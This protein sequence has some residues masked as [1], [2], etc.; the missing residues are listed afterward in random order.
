[1]AVQHDAPPAIPPS[2]F[3]RS[4]IVSMIASI[5]LI[6]VPYV[7]TWGF[8]NPGVSGYRVRLAMGP[9]YGLSIICL[10]PFVQGFIYGWQCAGYR[11]ELWHALAGI[12]ILAVD[13]G[14]A[15]AIFGEGYIC[16][17]MAL[18]ILI[19]ILAVGIAVGKSLGTVR[20]RRLLQ[21]SLVPLVLSFVVVDTQNGPPVHS[22]AISDAVTIAAAPDYV[23]RYMVQY[24]VNESPPEYWLWKIGLPAPT[25]SVAA[26]AAI[27]AV[28]ECRFT[29]GVV[30]KEEITELVA[31]K[32]LIFKVTEQP[33]DPELLHHFSLDKGQLYLED[34]GDGTT[35]VIAT[36]WYRLFVEPALYFDWWAADNVR[37]VH[38]RVLNHVKRLAEADWRRDH[39]SAN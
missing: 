16:V 27:G 1:M 23:W 14:L 24:P 38:F 8:M 17:I 13:I 22:N 5:V 3:W 30:F 18:P 4:L 36:S 12:L 26:T 7:L 20:R 9:G 34:N 6:A 37:Q 31:N 29:H 25:Q 19:P 15:A 2:L 10:F 11:V 28:R 35:T 32:M 33:D 21:V 39:P